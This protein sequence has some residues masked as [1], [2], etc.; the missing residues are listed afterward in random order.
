MDHL[1]NAHGI[2]KDSKHPSIMSKQASQARADCKQRALDAGMTE[3]RFQSICTT[4]YIIRRLLPFS[5]VEYPE[6]RTTVHPA[7]K[8]ITAETQRNLVAEMYLMSSLM[9]I[10]THT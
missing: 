10:A 6:F 1:A 5:H 9:Y 8:V 3:V 4:R 2:A 7:W